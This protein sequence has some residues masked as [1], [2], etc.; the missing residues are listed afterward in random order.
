MLLFGA[1][2]VLIMVWRPGGLISRREP[3]VR[4]GRGAEGEDKGGAPR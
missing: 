4:L 3:T 2:M 1:A